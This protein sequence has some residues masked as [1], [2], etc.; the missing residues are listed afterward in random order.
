MARAEAVHVQETRLGAG[1]SQPP[2]GPACPS[3]AMAIRASAMAS[4]PFSRMCRW[5]LRSC[6]VVVVQRWHARMVEV[7]SG[8]AVAAAGKLLMG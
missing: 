5:L 3:G 1:A 4:A 2:L 7:V 6:V 8:V